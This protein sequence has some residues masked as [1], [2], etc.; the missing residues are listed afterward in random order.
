MGF[1]IYYDNLLLAIN[2][3]LD[4]LLRGSE[5]RH[6]ALSSLS[7]AFIETYSFLKDNHNQPKRN[8]QIAKLWSKAALSV[9][10]LDRNLSQLLE[11]K[12]R[13]FLDPDLFNEHRRMNEV[14]QIKNIVDEMERIK[15]RFPA[16]LNK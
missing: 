1:G 10:P 5:I 2:G 6:Q 14:I 4:L 13:F 7:E 12:S 16:G 11:T 3:I 8:I 15:L 9:E